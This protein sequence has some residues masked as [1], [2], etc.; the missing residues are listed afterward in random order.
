MI[1]RIVICGKDAAYISKRN[2]ERYFLFDRR[3]FVVT[4]IQTKTESYKMRIEYS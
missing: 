1:D 3:T 4:A 2:F